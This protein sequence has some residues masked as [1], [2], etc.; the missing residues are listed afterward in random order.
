MPGLMV[1]AQFAILAAAAQVALA[2][3]TP[4][5]AAQINFYTDTKCSAYAGEA[6]AFWT[7]LPLVGGIG[8]TVSLLPT[9]GYGVGNLSGG[10]CS[11]V[12]AARAQCITLNMPGNSQSINTAALWGYSTTTEPGTGSGNCV[13]WD[14]YTAST[15]TVNPTGFFFTGPR[16]LT[17]CAPATITWS[18]ESATPLLPD[19]TLGLANENITIVITDGLIQRQ[20]QKYTWPSVNL[21]EGIYNLV[22]LL[23]LAPTNP[24]QFAVQVSNGT[25]TSCLT[26]ASNP[27]RPSAVSSSSTDIPASSASRS[28]TT[29]N[30]S[31][32]GSSRPSRGVIA[33]AVVGALAL[34]TGVLTAYFCVYRRSPRRKH[35]SHDRPLM[36]NYTQTDLGGLTILVPSVMEPQEA[37]QPRRDGILPRD[38]SN[39]PAGPENPE[40]VQRLREITERMGFIEERMQDHGLSADEPPPG[41]L[42]H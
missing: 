23:L 30:A 40:T 41:Y 9:L 42:A 4:D 20:A 5:K 17:T 38:A 1:F 11:T 16:N 3:W 12:G 37:A 28:S 6:A 24:S 35:P 14:D 18:Y 15:P 21:T 36:Q 2:N 32:R 33:G 27:A 8:S 13:F 7:Q 10:D 22:A 34:I 25:D 39:Q 31:E 19:L 29:S 26:S